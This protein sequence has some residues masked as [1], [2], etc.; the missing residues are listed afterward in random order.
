MLKVFVPAKPVPKQSFR[1]GRRGSGW[2]PKRVTTYQRTARRCAAFAV[3]KQ[4]WTTVPKGEPVEVRVV[5][6]WPWPKSTRKAERDLWSYR[7]VRPDADNGAKMLLDALSKARVWED[8]EQVVRLQV[9]KVT[10]PRG[11]EGALVIVEAIN[12][13][14]ERPYTDLEGFCRP[15]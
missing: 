3:R 15:V 12:D 6:A 13:P 14:T 10:V 4:G 8:D 9:T 1:V 2:Q 5:L 11:N 7:T